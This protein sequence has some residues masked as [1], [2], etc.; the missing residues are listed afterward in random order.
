MA[1]INCKECGKEMSENATACPNCGNPNTLTKEEKQAEIKKKENEN[2]TSVIV[3]V[4]ILVVVIGGTIWGMT[5]WDNNDMD[6]KIMNGVVDGIN[7]LT[8]TYIDYEYE[9]ERE[10]ELRNRVYDALNID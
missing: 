3:I 9:K 5:W 10:K 2:T 1:L 6:N 8:D 4:I 7:S